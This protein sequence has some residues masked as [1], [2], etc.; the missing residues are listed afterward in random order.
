MFENTGAYSIRLAVRD[1]PT[2]DN[3]ALDGYRLWS[4]TEQYDRLLLVQTRPAASVSVTVSEDSEDSSECIANA[5]YE[6]YD[7]D[8]TDDSTQGIREE[9]FCYK[10]VKDAG[11]TEGKLPNRLA[12]GCTYLVKYQVKDAEG[13]LSFPAVYY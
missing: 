6:A 4:D 9:Y 10:N 5:V 12:A 3:D 1:N 13:T 8:H 11:W 2:G 7:A